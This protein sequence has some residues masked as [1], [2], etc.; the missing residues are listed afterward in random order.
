VSPPSKPSSR[1]LEQV[2]LGALGGA[3]L[4]ASPDN[5]A[6]RA[7]VRTAGLALIAYAASPLI[8][9]AVRAAGA[10]RR[11]IAFRSSFEVDRPLPAVFAFFKDFENLPRVIGAVD[12]VVDYQDGRSHW[13]GYTPAG[14]PIEWDVVITKYVPNTVIGWE[15][16]ASSPVDVRAQ[17]RFAPVSATRTRI[18]VEVYFSPAATGFGD[19]IHALFAVANERR[20]KMELDHVRFYLESVLPEESP[21]AAAVAPAAD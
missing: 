5:R 21:T 1:S 4:A 16:T 12:S 18:D 13:V 7:L 17:L 14:Q 11:R 10:R 6:T 19:A 2:A 15:S 9:R 3:L 8:D 20:L